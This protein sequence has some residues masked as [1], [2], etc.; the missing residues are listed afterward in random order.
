MQ[1]IKVFF[2]EDDPL[3]EPCPTPEQRMAAV[4]AGYAGFVG[5]ERAI[6]KL[7]AWAFDALGRPDHM[8][9]ELAFADAEGP[10]A[11]GTRVKE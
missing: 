3:G 10:R 1:T 11:F 8:C 4:N 2:G 7:K 9:R 5:N 6:K